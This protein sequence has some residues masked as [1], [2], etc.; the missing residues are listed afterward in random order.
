LAKTKKTTTTT[1]SDIGKKILVNVILDRSG[2]MG[3]IRES[4]R[5]GYNDYLRELRQDKSTEYS[6]TLTQ[7][8]APGAEPELTV[9]YLDKPLA[10]IEDLK[11]D[12][13]VPRGSTPLYDAIGETLRRVEGKENGRPVLD[14]VITDGQENFSREFNKESIKALIKEKEAHGHT[15]VF[16]GANIDSYAVAGAIGA[17][18]GNTSNYQPTAGHVH[19]LYAAAGTATV[20]YASMRKSSGIRGQSVGESFFTPT[21]KSAMG[22]TDQPDDPI[23]SAAKALGA[24]GGKARTANLTPPQ[25][26]RMAQKAAQTRWNVTKK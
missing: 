23:T 3:V 20:N 8:D 15:F 21:M 7:F 18:M 9:L 4:T 25:R 22:D 10:E 24:L 17:S 13:Y 14:V 5:T 1:K 19:A 26:S 16:L 6:I 11:E 12:E 2:S